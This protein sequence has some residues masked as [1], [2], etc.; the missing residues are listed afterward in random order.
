MYYLL[1]I[2]AL[3]LVH[4]SIIKNKWFVSVDVQ[5][6]GQNIY[7]YYYLYRFGDN[8][9]DRKTDGLSIWTANG[10]MSCALYP[11]SGKRWN[12]YEKIYIWNCIGKAQMKSV[13]SPVNWQ[14]MEEL[15][16]D[17]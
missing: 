5:D 17:H 8:T 15:I 12:Y 2:P 16:K 1:V 13:N 7:D 6:F 11:H 10:F 3:Y 9:T 4:R 14:K